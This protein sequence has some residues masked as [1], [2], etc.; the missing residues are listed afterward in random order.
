LEEKQRE[1]T[2]ELEKPETYEKS[3]LAMSL[4]RDLMHITDELAELTP[5]WE[6][7]TAALLEWEKEQELLSQ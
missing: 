7:A 6:A 1:L 2:A 5:K 3:G 4:N